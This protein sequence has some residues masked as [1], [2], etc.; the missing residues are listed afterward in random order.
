MPVHSPLFQE[1]DAIITREVLTLKKKMAAPRIPSRVMREHLLRVVYAEM[2]GHDA[3]FGYIRAVEMT[4]S[5]NILEKRTGYMVA[6]LTLA[7]EHEF[8]F[9]IVNQMQRDMRSANRLE[10][11]AGL[12]AVS[13]IVTADMIPAGGWVV[14]CE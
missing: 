14:G 3:S 10:V 9:M 12:T 1:E 4:A 13:K 8:R 2:L 6:G 7:P 5:R 11:C